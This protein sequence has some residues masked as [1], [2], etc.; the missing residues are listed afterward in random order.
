MGF[1]SADS[2]DEAGFASYVLKILDES[3]KKGNGKLFKFGRLNIFG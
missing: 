3:N 1:A 2:G